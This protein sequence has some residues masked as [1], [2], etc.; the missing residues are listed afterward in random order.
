MVK[1][2][3]LPAKLL[4]LAKTRLAPALSDHDRMRVAAAMF[5][6]VLRSL[7]RAATLDAVIVVTA[8]PQ[9]ADHARTAGALVVDEGTP[10]G[11]NGAVLLGT[12]TALRLGATSLVV[13]LSDI[14][15]VVP[16]DVD[17]LT[18]RAPECGAVVVPSKEGTGTNAMLRRPPALFTPCFGGRSLRRHVAAAERHRVACAI[19]RNV[20]IAF[21]LDTPDDLRIFAERETDTETYR[22]VARVG[23]AMLRPSV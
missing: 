6:D 11:L 23:A 20:R 13:V 21:D 15:L 4:S 10:R 16:A 9:L 22:T 18:S 8:D 5:D 19:V 3:L 12:D 2:A 14:P 1:V 17:E 7:Q